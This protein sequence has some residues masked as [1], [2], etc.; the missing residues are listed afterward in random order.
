MLRV[1]RTGSVL[2]VV[3]RLAK[4]RVLAVL[5]GV[6]LGAALTS[7]RPAP[8]L[9]WALGAAA[10]LT[11]VLGGRA[12]RARFEAGRVSVRQAVPFQR[13]A[14]RPLAEFA[15]AAV[16]TAGEARRRKAERRA[17][18]Y[19]ERSGTEMPAWLRAP[20][21]PA[22]NDRLRRIVLV[23]RAGEPLPVTSWLAEDDVEPARVEIEALLR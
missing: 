22:T 10:A 20:L 7:A 3:S 2:T 5:A 16:E 11:A 1:D 15:G 23:S 8:A 9:A 4:A 6:L 13:R 19:R 21:A 14:V 17:A 12:V 18:G